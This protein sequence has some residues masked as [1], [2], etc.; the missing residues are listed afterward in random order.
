VWSLPAGSGALVIP[1]GEM[2]GFE[3]RRGAQK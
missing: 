1:S 2:R 3:A